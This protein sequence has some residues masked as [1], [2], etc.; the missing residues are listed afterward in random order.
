MAA[1]I[2]S[3]KARQIFDSRGNPTVEVR[4][5]LPSPAFSG[6]ISIQAWSLHA[7]LRPRFID[8]AWRSS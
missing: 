1:S 5:S 4:A 2:Q 7:V 8:L 6:S 3:V